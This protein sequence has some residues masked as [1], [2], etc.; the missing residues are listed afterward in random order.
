MKREKY[1]PRTLAERPTEPFRDAEE[2]WFWFC[3]CQIAR[4]DGAVLDSNGAMFG[5]PCDPDDIHRAVTGLRR[6]R[7]LDQAH[8]RVLGR[9]GLAMSPPDG[10]ARDQEIDARYWDEALDRLTTVL[11]HK[12]IVSC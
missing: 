3:R 2:A 6:Q 8:V 7:R 12:G 1:S 5:R 10:R 4:R 9:Y 11:R